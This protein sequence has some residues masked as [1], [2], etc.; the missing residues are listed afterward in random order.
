MPKPTGGRPKNEPTD[1][2][3]ELVKKVN[4]CKVLDI[5][6]K[7]KVINRIKQGQTELAK[8]SASVFEYK[9][10]MNDMNNYYSEL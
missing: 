7:L 6:T 1:A 5:N 10:Y 8:K 4:S 3:Q 2:I 9:I